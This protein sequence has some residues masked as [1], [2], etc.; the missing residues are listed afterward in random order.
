MNLH[1]SLG[2]NLSLFFLLAITIIA[3][4]IYRVAD[5]ALSKLDNPDHR[6]EI[7]ELLE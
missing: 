5:G 1:Q 4:A 7:N 3:A 2:K 6:A